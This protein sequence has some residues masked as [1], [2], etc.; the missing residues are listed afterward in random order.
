MIAIKTRAQIGISALPV[1]VEA[2]ILAGSPSFNL[3]GLAK[4][5]VRESRDRV[6]SAIKNAGLRYPK[7]KIVVNL[8][9]AD[10][11]K[12]GGRYD[13]AIAY[14]SAGGQRPASFGSTR[15]VRIHG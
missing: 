9:P 14:E 2:H 11:A 8:A 13:L 6:K 7:G 3:V 5:A 15:C 10:I 1:H 4:T 12:D